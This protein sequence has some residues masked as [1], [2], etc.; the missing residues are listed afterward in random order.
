MLKLADQEIPGRITNV[1]ARGAYFAMEKAMPAM[2]GEGTLTCEGAAGVIVKVAWTS[3]YG[4]G[5]TLMGP[6]RSNKLC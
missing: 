4:C 1:S 6:E 5:L 2:D 3:A